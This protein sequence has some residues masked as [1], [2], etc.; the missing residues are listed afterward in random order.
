[1]LL[2][3]PCT[4]TPGAGGLLTVPFPA[5]PGPGYGEI[6]DLARVSEPRPVPDLVA[7]DPSPVRPLPGP[8]PLPIPV[9][10]PEPPKP[11]L[12][13]PAGDK[14]RAPGPPLL[15]RPTFEPGWLETTKPMPG[16]LP[17]ELLGGALTELASNR[18]PRPEPRL[19]CP[20][21]EIDGSPVTDGGGGT[22]LPAPPRLAICLAGTDPPLTTGA[23]GT[24]DP[25]PASSAI[26]RALFDVLF[27]PLTC[28]GGGTT[29]SV[30]TEPA[31][32]RLPVAAPFNCTGGGTTES[33]AL[34][35]P[36]AAC[37]LLEVPLICTGGGTTCFCS[38]PDPKLGPKGFKSCVISV[39]GG[40]TTVA[41][42]ASLGCKW[43]I[44][45]GAET[46]GA[47][48][49]TACEPGR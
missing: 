25:L 1:M 36:E 20:N 10:P 7:P 16:A 37:G 39:G 41:G 38:S 44:C 30:C 11:G 18:P 27:A 13:P 17:P 32:A 43:V 22:T 9:P 26:C 47:T 35:N 15:G 8:E 33:L 42:R 12:S 46:G 14:A 3:P 6:P 40:A 23:G 2:L 45:S 28:T 48:T 31:M 24:T 21:P 29:L 34:P 19:P 5:P 49:A 4:E